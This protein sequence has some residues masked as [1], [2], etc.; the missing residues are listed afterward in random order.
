MVTHVKQGDMHALHAPELKKYPVSHKHW[1]PVKTQC[2]P[3]PVTQ[4]RH[5]TPVPSFE[6]VK[7]GLTH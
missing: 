1:L 5:S 4:L 7:Q 2:K 3:A 6:Q